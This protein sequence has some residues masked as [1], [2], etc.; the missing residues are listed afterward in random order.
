[1]KL[2]I[3]SKFF[4]GIQ[5]GFKV[6]HWTRWELTHPFI[7]LIWWLLLIRQWKGRTSTCNIGRRLHH[8]ILVR[9]NSIR[10]T[11]VLPNWRKTWSNSILGHASHWGILLLSC[12]SLVVIVG[13]SSTDTTAWHSTHR[14]LVLHRRWL[15][16]W[17]VLHRRWLLRLLIERSWNVLWHI[18]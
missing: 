18:A 16:N 2:I 7:I 6:H 4:Q 5:S 14:R 11:L 12:R 15:L 13:H 8:I 9:S 1:M 17:L 10:K 3:L